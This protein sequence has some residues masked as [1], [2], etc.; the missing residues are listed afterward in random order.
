MILDTTNPRSSCKAG[1][2]PALKTRGLRAVI[3]LALVTVNL[4]L[5]LPSMS[6]DFLWDDKQFISENPHIQGPGF[7]RTFAVSP[8]GGFT[9]GDENSR[10]Q[11]RVMRFYRPL[12]SLSY[13]VD[14]RIWG[15]NSAAFHLTNILIQTINAIIL[16]YVLGELALGLW[17]AFFGALLFSTYPLHF[18]NVAWISGRTDLLAFLFAGLSVLSF[19]RFVKTG[20]RLPLL[21]SGAAYFLGLLGKENV[22]LLP[23]AFF[24]VLHRREARP[25]RALTRLWPHALA[26]AGWLALRFNAVGAAN[27]GGSGRSVRDLLTAVGFYGWRTIFPF[28]PSLTVDPLPVFRNT[29]LLVLGAALVG[30]LALSVRQAWRKDP[31]PAWP[32]W[33]FLGWALFLFPSVAV[34]FSPTAISLLAWRFLYLPS[35]VLAAALAWLLERHSRMRRAAVAAVLLLTGLCGV[36]LYQKSSLFGQDETNF[37]LSLDKPEREDVVARFNVAIK[38]LPTDEPRSLRLFDSILERREQPSY[39]YWQARVNEELGVYYAFKKEFG[40]AEACFR[41]IFRSTPRPSL[42]LSFNYAFYLA[43]AGKTDEGEKTVLEKLAQFPANHFVLVQ[44]AKYY[45]IVRDYARAAALYNEDFRL[46]RTPQS[47]QLA[48]QASR[49]APGT[50]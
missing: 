2:S 24:L 20:K 41:E 43:F 6:G 45:V 4:A 47:R 32:Y 19:I 17:A 46:F 48:D 18:E 36:G 30:L 28:S 16:F 37:W 22:I 12:V 7:L 5:F 40:R 9:G 11:D 34:I 25:G 35:A 49:L 29:A 42:R 31:A 1:P 3:L 33:A 27:L 23:L 26:L 14:F 39:A 10:E 44:A 50:R 21:V 38:A 8:F 13:W 15:L